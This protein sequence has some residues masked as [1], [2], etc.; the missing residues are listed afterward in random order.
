MEAIEFTKHRLYKPTYGSTDYSDSSDEGEKM[1][2]DT[3]QPV[4]TKN[5]KKKLQKKAKKPQHKQLPIPQTSTSKQKQPQTQDEVKHVYIQALLH[6]FEIRVFSYGLRVYSSIFTNQDSLA[7]IFSFLEKKVGN[8]VEH[9]ISRADQNLV[10]SGILHQYTQQTISKSVS[11]NQQSLQNPPVNPDAM[12]IFP[13]ADTV[14]LPPSNGIHDAKPNKSKKAATK[15][16]EK[17]YVNQIIPDDKMNNFRL[18]LNDLPQDSNYWQL[19]DHTKP[20]TIFSHYPIKALKHFNSGGKS[21]IVAYFEK[22]QDVESCRKTSFNFN[23]NGTDHSLPWCASPISSQNKN[24]KPT[25][26]SN[27]QNSGSPKAYS[28][29]SKPTKDTE[30]SSK[31]SKG[32]KKKKS[33]GNKSNDKMD[34]VKLRLALI[35]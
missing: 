13:D 15:S 16:I 33:S 26:N 23:H 24:K 20:S 14:L 8:T 30:K 6:S 22:Y 4:L 5:Q 1:L 28:T 17:V 29:I 2:D 10:N 32:N 3:F 21:Q 18:Y 25:K 31:K 34:I 35:S 11:A 9:G 12:Q 19:W 7:E 27:K